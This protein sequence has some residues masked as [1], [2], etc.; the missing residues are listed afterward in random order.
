MLR[1]RG[2]H[3]GSSIGPLEKSC[4]EIGGLE[5]WRKT[6]V[7]SIHCVSCV[8]QLQ[9]EHD[10]LCGGPQYFNNNSATPKTP[11]FNFINPVLHNKLGSKSVVCTSTSSCQSCHLVS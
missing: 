11:F 5:G 9:R 1:E 7:V 3:T 4:K 6:Y 2:I 10:V 8:V